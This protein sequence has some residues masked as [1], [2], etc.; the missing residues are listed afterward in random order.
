MNEGEKQ[1]LLT[2]FSQLINATEAKLRGLGL[3]YVKLYTVDN[4][5][6][7]P[8]TN[9]DRLIEMAEKKCV[10]SAEEGKPHNK[11]CPVVRVTARDAAERPATEAGAG[12]G[13]DGPY[14]EGRPG[15]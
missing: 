7:Q 1:A 3:T 9:Y 4:R 14:G 11:G 5:D 13:S 2:Q 12:H 10:C 8:I 6:G 15:E